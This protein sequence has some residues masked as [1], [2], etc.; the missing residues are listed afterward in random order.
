MPSILLVDDDAGLR[1]PMSYA[2]TLAGHTVTSA[3]DG[4]SALRLATETPFD[5]VITDIVMPE[6]DGLELIRSIRAISP[7][8]KIIGMSGGG[9]GAADNYLEIA[10]RFGAALVLT[11][12]FAIEDLIGA[13]N[14][15]LV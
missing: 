9:R 14:S 4:K 8:T 2:L 5:I 12:P 3:A 13:V 7:A 6:M 10:E 1:V 15:V 11:K